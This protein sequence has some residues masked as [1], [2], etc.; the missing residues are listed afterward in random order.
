MEEKMWR[1]SW[2]QGA[3][4]CIICIEN[5]NSSLG[6]KHSIS[7][8]ICRNVF[9]DW[10]LLSV[11]HLPIQA[12]LKHINLIVL[13]SQISAWTFGSSLHVHSIPFLLLVYNWFTFIG[14]PQGTVAGQ[15]NTIEI[16]LN[17]KH[18]GHVS[19]EHHGNNKCTSTSWSWVASGWSK[20]LQLE[21]QCD[22]FLCVWCIIYSKARICS[23]SFVGSMLFNQEVLWQQ[24]LV[25]LSVRIVTKGLILV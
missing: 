8:P 9:K 19:R 7:M 5:I 24:H 1:Y 15:A 16:K 25:F 13:G 12:M 17:Q 6:L 18:N 22:E 14:K 11:V 3:K 4:C 2:L 10:Y 23:K 21:C 20:L